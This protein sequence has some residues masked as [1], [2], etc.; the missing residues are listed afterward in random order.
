[1]SFPTDTHIYF[2]F[3]WQTQV[4]EFAS[5]LFFFRRVSASFYFAYGKT[6]E[7]IQ[8][9]E[10]LNKP[11]VLLKA[12]LIC[13]LYRCHIGYFISFSLW[14]TLLEAEMRSY[15]D[16]F[17]LFSNGYLFC[18]PRYPTR[19]LGVPDSITCLQVTNKHQQQ[20]LAHGH[21][22]FITL[23]AEVRNWMGSAPQNSQL[24]SQ[25]FH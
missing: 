7:N 17:H 5:K 23:K 4:S 11:K 1:M 19:T 18:E 21:I 2:A 16:L 8:W 25:L 10:G 24:P 6:H 20:Y 3:I 15:L 9:R 12:K 13:S 14:R 22:S